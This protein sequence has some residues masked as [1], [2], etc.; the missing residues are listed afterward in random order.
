M[1]IPAHVKTIADQLHS[2]FVPKTPVDKE[3]SFQFTIH[4]NTTYLVHYQKLVIK[5]KDTWVLTASEQIM[6]A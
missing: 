4:P 3:F 5:G 2:G 1:D 6:P